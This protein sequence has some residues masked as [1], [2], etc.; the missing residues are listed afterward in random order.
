ML[1]AFTLS[2]RSCP[3]ALVLACA[4]GGGVAEEA[5]DNIPDG[6]TSPLF[7]TQ[8]ERIV[9]FRNFDTIFETRAIDHGSSHLALE[10]DPR[11]FS[12]LSYRVGES[13]HTLEDYLENHFVAG[14][15]V[16]KGERILL[17]RYRL[18]HDE[19][20]RWVS[21]SIAKSVTSLLIGAAIHDGYIESLDETVTDYLPRLKGTAYDRSSIRDILQM[22][23]GIAWNEDYADPQSDVALAGAANGLAL[24][25]YLAKLPAESEPGERFN[26][27][28]AETNL[29]GALLRAAIGN[30]ASSYLAAKIWRPFMEH[31]ATWSITADVELGGCCI[32]ATLRD[33]AR[34]GQFALRDGVLPGAERVLPEGWI[35]ESTAASPAN[36]GYGYLWW[37]WGDN[38]YAA[39]GIFGQLIWID[40]ENEVVIVMHSAWPAATGSGLHNH[41]YA[42]V[43]ALHR[44]ALEA[45]AGR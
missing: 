31:P 14:L 12:E 6:S 25:E 41:E 20:T 24:Y 30:N 4:T 33:Y 17:E 42:L 39:M 11:D 35:K 9:G 40:P 23:S 7:W 1:N 18:G 44:R 45:D 10:R 22:A 28:T 15:L 27:N 43:G 19:T 26:Y 29:V 38:A 34:I 2:R 13:T 36:P 3:A 8:D 21:Y 37:R 5:V 32:H 16:V